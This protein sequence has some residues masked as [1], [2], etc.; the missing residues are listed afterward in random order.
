MYSYVIDMFKVILILMFMM[1]V[2]CCFNGAAKRKLILASDFGLDLLDQ[3]F[4]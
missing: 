3:G 4:F 2:P 1:Y